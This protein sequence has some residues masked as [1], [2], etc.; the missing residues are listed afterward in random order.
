MALP[1]MGCTQGTNHP[2]EFGAVTEANVL[3]GCIRAG[4]EDPGTERLVIVDDGADNDDSNDEVQFVGEVS[5]QERSACE[6][7]YDGIVQEFG[8]DAD[9]FQDFEDLAADLDEVLEAAGEDGDTT[10]TRTNELDALAE[11]ADTCFPAT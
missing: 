8:D 9:G 2:E 1:L 5:D 4:R 11:V 6:C 7:L 10:T 3:D